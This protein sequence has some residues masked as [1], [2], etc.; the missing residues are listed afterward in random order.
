MQKSSDN[1]SQWLAVFKSMKISRMKYSANDMQYNYGNN[2][3]AQ[4]PLKHFQLFFFFY[5][6]EFSNKDV[7]QDLNRLLKLG[8]TGNSA[9]L[10][11]LDIFCLEILF[12]TFLQ[13]SLKKTF[14]P[15]LSFRTGS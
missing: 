15:L 5:P 11:T 14:S 8:A 1:N 7:V 13:W 6:A 4:F 3:D 2:K 12:A 9:T 10:G